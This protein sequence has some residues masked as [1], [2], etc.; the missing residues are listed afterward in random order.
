[1]E[2]S[3]IETIRSQIPMNENPR[4]N[5]NNPPI[6]ATKEDGGYNKVSSCIRLVLKIL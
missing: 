1:M 6:S 2:N 3:I 4:N 5:P